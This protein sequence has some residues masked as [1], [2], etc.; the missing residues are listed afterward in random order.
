MNFRLFCRKSWV[1]LI[2]VSLLQSGFQMSLRIDEFSS[3]VQ[4][5]AHYYSDS[6][7]LIDLSRYDSKS[8]KY[9]LARELSPHSAEFLDVFIL[10]HRS[11]S[12]KNC[13][14]DVRVVF[15]HKQRSVATFS[16][17]FRF[18]STI[19]IIGDKRSLDYGDKLVKIA[20]IFLDFV[21]WPK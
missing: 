2:G 13:S 6:G 9:E 14:F 1:R 19:A 4:S 11:Q 3:F 12:A 16:H 10:G 7:I 20:V 15:K 17:K 21:K 8:K 5:K 18:N